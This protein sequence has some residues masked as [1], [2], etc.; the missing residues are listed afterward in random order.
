MNF[1]L[2]FLLLI[3]VS[4]EFY[5]STSTFWCFQLKYPEFK[6][7]SPTIK[8]YKIKNSKTI[9]ILKQTILYKSSPINL[10]KKKKLYIKKIY[11]QISTKLQFYGHQVNSYERV[12]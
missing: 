3:C 5:S 7:L 9:I 12:I 6:S 8:L 11:F 4:Q 10:A 2:R 1:A